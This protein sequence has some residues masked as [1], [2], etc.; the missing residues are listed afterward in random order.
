VDA[1]GN[2]SGTLDTLGG[3]PFSATVGGGTLTGVLD[4]SFT[5]EG[6]TITITGALNAYR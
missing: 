4:T 3:V 5:F 2:L 1:S 6:Q